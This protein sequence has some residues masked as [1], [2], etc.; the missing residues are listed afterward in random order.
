[1][2]F[3]ILAGVYGALTVFVIIG[4]ISG[5][6]S[7]SRRQILHRAKRMEDQR[8]GVRRRD[9]EQVGGDGADLL[10]DQRLA[11]NK[12]IASFISRF[13]WA[14]RRAR[15]LEQG[16]VPI[17]VGEY[18]LMLALTALAGMAIAWFLSGFPPAGL[19]VAVF[20][21][22][23]GET[24]V[25]RR[26]AQRR[27]KF[28]RQLPNALQMMGS[29]LQSGFGIMDAIRTVAHDMEQPL[30]TEFGRILD[31]TRA[32]G[33][34]EAALERLAERMG[35]SDLRIVVQAL[36]IHRQ[37]GGDLGGILAQVAM[38]MREREKLRRDISSMTAQE[39]MSATIVAALPIF[40]LGF[41]IVSDKTLVESL[42]TTQ[43]GQILSG[44]AIALEVV[45]FIL[46]RRVTKL[47]A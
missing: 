47:E 20:I 16:D 23:V 26:A 14:E 44:T 7:T 13:S 31:E 45:G 11:T 39:R 30:S 37:V 41:F 8:L 24:W 38:T 43:L 5:S 18:A 28:S 40:A 4:L 1:M 42:W 21:V 35:G 3:P 33:S 6:F 32:G 25:S 34:F 2:T 46:M 12:Q 19:V 36:T 29:S 17:K 15:T 22:M 9:A 10:R 27:E